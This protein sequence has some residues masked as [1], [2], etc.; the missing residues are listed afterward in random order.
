MTNEIRILKEEHHWTSEEKLKHFGYGEWVEEADVTEFEYLGYIAYVY[1]VFM[2]EPDL[3]EEAY[4]G[5]HL[6]GYVKV[7]ED[8]HLFGKRSEC[9][10]ADLDCHQGIT[11]S[12]FHE[13]HWIGFDCAHSGDY[14]P[15]ME[16]MRKKRRYSG[17]FEL[18][19]IPEGFENCT[20]FH[21]VYRNMEYCI[22][23]CKRLIESLIELSKSKKTAAEQE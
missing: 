4:F 14:V 17:E 1:R 23:E 3:K 12:E 10:D 11:F 22:Y 8:H 20:L 16:M 5:G 21:P 18:F 6:C 2:R 19:P 7:P 9:W 13:E 15:T